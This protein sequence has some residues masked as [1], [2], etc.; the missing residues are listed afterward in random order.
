MNDESIYQ[1]INQN[2]I[3]DKLISLVTYIINLSS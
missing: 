3:A 1:S 2:I